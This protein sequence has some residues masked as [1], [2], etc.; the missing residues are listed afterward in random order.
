MKTFIYFRHPV[1][2]SAEVVELEGDDVARHSFQDG[3]FYKYGTSL[4]PLELITYLETSGFV[5]YKE[6]SALPDLQA[7]KNEFPEHFL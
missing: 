3:D 7:L 4:S 1:R 2:G 6:S 5:R